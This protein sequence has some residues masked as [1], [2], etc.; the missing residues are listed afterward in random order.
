MSPK[1]RTRSPHAETKSRAISVTA[2]VAE[3][4]TL[5]KRQRPSEKMEAAFSD[6]LTFHLSES[7]VGC[8]ARRRTRF[9]I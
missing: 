8:V 7:R 4:H 6:G 9:Q 1:R 2:C 5:H 3:P